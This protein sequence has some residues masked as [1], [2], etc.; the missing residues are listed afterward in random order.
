M[1][2]L[3]TRVRVRPCRE[4]AS[5]SSF[6][7][8]TTIS[9]PSLVTVIGSTTLWRS[10]PLGPLTVTC[11]PSML[12]STPA[13]TGI[14]SRPIR[15][16]SAPPLPDVGENFPAYLLLGGLTIGQ[17]TGRGR[18]DGDTE[19]TEDLGQLGRARVDPQAGLR[20][21]ADP[22]DRALTVGAVLELDDQRLAHWR[23][24]GGPGGDVALLDQDVGD[25]ALQLREG[26]DD[27]VVIRR[28]GVADPGEEIR[29]RVG[30]GHV[31]SCLSRL[32]PDTAARGWACDEVRA[33]LKAPLWLMPTLVVAGGT[34]SL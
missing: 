33:L 1:T 5:R 25:G 2:M 29:D 32:V 16:M 20:D 4:R 31:R 12:T 3:L 18:D 15:D 13:G 11:D 22:G 7:L 21:A 10:D 8:V 27:L 14:G 30:H 6:G 28:V 26:H 24:G 19:A 17:Q 9:A 23:V 34:F